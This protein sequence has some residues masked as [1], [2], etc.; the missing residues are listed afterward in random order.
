MRIGILIN[1]NAAGGQASGAL[2]ALGCLNVDSV[3][4]RETSRLEEIAPALL[5]LQAQGIDVLV[6]YGGDGTISRVLE[7]AYGVWGDDLPALYAV[8]AG[9]INMIA[10]SLRMPRQKPAAAIRQLAAA[11]PA[12]RQIVQRRALQS[13]LGPMGFTFGFG[14]P[15]RFLQEYAGSGAL[16]AIALLGRAA[17]SLPRRQ[18]LAA[19]LL[20]PVDLRWQLRDGDLANSWQADSL[21]LFLAMTIDELSLGFRVAPGAGDDGEAMH[22]IYG[23]PAPGFVIR[24]LHRFHAGE[25]VTGPDL[26]RMR[27]RQLSFEF[28]QP[29]GWMIDGEIHA[30]V[31]A[32]GLQLGPMVRFVV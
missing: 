10:N 17:L 13:S 7:A 32:L 27:S 16:G 25:R 6:P 4:V 18:G 28:G 15:V 11:E 3:I 22:L 8:R 29:T 24:N 20:A 12:A 21:R 1:R 31:A 9:T 5:S 14:A 26:H 23:N 2:K 19:R 30:P